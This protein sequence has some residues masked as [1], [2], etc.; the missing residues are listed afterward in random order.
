V[1]VLR[2]LERLQIPVH[3]IAGVSAGS[4]VAA[5][6]ASGATPEEIG[7]AGCA[8][9]F[10]DVARWIPGRLGLAGSE[11][12]TDFLCRLLKRTRFEHMA[13]PLAVVATDLITGEPVVFRGEGDV[14]RPIRASCSYPG[15]LQPVRHDGRLLVDGAMSMEVPARVLRE[16]GATFVIGVSLPAQA[17]GGEP[18]NAFQV[19]NRCFQILQAR[20]EN[21][22]RSAC[23]LVIEPDVRGMAWDSFGCGEQLIRAGEIAA[24]QQIREPL[25]R[26]SGTP[27]ALRVNLSS[28]SADFPF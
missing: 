12:M 4:I 23:D 10:S 19:I 22:W 11:R 25:S 7:R 24:E 26:V 27:A 9:R 17:D 18:R 1:G 5:A 14:C 15:L 16:V 21:D 6:Y 3:S 8:M 28:L 20:N 13:M 2:V